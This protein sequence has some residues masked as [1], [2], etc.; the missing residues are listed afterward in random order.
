SSVRCVWFRI[1][2]SLRRALHVWLTLRR[3]KQ[4]NANPLLGP[5]AFV[6]ASAAVGATSGA[7]APT[8]RSAAARTSAAY[9]LYVGTS[10]PAT[11]KKPE[12]RQRLLS[13]STIDPGHI[14]DTRDLVPPAVWEAAQTEYGER[15]Q[16][17]FP[18]LRAWDV[19]DLPWAGEVAP[20]AYRALG[21]MEI[22]A[23]LFVSLTLSE[24]PF[25]NWRSP[26]SRSHCSPPRRVAS[27]FVDTWML[28]NC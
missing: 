14:V 24:L 16:F 11:T 19:M 20:V 3:P 1:S 6:L 27:P 12:H 23:V 17:S 9:S 8:T 5:V 10:N 15:W 4:R 18:I 13:L 26:K 25:G 28:R 7:C 22:G 2:Q 21:F